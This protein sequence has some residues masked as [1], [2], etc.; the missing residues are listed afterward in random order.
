MTNL[1]SSATNTWRFK[2]SWKKCSPDDFPSDAVY[3]G[4]SR[5]EANKVA[6][7]GHA[8]P[9][10]PLSLIGNDWEV[11][12]YA[13]E[14]QLEEKSPEEAEKFLSTV[15]P[16]W[17]TRQGVNLTTDFNNAMGYAQ[18]R[19]GKILVFDISQL[20]YDEIYQPSDVHIQAK[21]PEKVQLIAVCDDEGENCLCRVKL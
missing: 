4:A 5:E 15:V 2:L 17:A 6:K 14:E 12:E 8:I 13:Y 20:D 3:R 9:Q 16:E 7:L 21:S 1:K 10:P 18:S 11:L 19:N